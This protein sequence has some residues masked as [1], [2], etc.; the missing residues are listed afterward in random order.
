MSESL[1]TYAN[2]RLML[3]PHYLVAGLAFGGAVCLSVYQLVRE[4]SLSAAIF[5]LL[6]SGASLLWFSVRMADLRLQDRLIRA[7]MR[8]RLERVLGA[9]RR[10]D[11]D[12]LSVKQMIALRFASDAELPGLVVEVLGGTTIESDAIKRK[13]REWQA[14][15]LRV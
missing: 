5:V 3:K 1:Q 9:S 14:D 7:E 15:T 4:P 8:A 12:R 11:I 13:V 10:L 2:H 6:S